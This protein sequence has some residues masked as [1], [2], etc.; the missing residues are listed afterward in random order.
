MQTIW[1]TYQLI[2]SIGVD[3]GTSKTD[4]SFDIVCAMIESMGMEITPRETVILCHPLMTI[5]KYHVNAHILSL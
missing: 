4:G 1:E 3:P 5:D 2:F